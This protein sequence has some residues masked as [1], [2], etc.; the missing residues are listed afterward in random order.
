MYDHYVPALIDSILHALGVPDAVHAL[1]AR[2]QPGRAAGDVRV[3]DGDLRADRACRSPTPP[4]TRARARSPPP[5]G[6][7]TRTRSKTKFLV[8]EGLHP[9]SRETLETTSAGWGTTIETIPLDERP[10]RSSARSA[11]T[12]PRS[13]SRSRTSTARSRTSRRCRA[14]KS[15]ALLIVQA[16]P[17][18]LGVL[19]APGRVRRRPLRRRGPDAR[20]PAGLR[21]PVASASSPPSRTTSA[22]CRAG[23]RARRPTS[24][25]A[26]ASCSRC[27]RASSTSAARRPRT[28]SARRRRST[29]SPGMIYLSWL[30]REG[31]VELGELLVSRTH[32]ARETLT[33][34]DGV[35]AVARPAGRARVRAQ[36]RCRR[37]TT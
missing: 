22:A 19:Q 24:T 3:P 15:G 1:P 12:S 4:S 13:S 27:R 5:A 20:Q 8:S 23:S 2:D 17:L 29:R 7:R 10:H 32:Y 6:S 34:I 11:T 33:A 28:T 21:R 25:A 18:T 30:G 14:A 36:A 35:E 9:H 31:I 37:R 16:D 26:A